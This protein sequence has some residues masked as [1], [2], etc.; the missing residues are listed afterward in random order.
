MTALQ[1]GHGIDDFA[2]SERKFV[3]FG[4]LEGY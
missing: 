1:R 4:E 2:T 3:G